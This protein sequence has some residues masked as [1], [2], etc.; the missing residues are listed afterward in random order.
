MTGVMDAGETEAG[1]LI[2]M[3][4]GMTAAVEETTAGEAVEAGTSAPNGAGMTMAARLTRTSM[5][6]S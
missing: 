3:T 1:M 2:A 4:T 5:C 6:R